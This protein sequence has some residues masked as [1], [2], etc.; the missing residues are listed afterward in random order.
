MSLFKLFETKD[1][2]KEPYA[3]YGSIKAEAVAMLSFPDVGLTLFLP[4][5]TFL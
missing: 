3:P 1:Y 4:G 5:L 2:L